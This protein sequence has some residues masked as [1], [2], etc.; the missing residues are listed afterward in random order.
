MRHLGLELRGV[1]RTKHR[2]WEHVALGIM[3]EKLSLES[4]DGGLKLRSNYVERK[5][6]GSEVPLSRKEK[7][8]ERLRGTEDLAT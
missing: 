4:V 5:S 3:T 1:C 6:Y 7:L 8:W 2:Q